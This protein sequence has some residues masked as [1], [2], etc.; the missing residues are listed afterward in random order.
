MPPE[1]KSKIKK[2][3][4]VPVLAFLAITSIFTFLKSTSAQI[5]S[6]CWSKD[7]CEKASCGEA[8]Y[9]ENVTACST[10]S[11]FCYA[12][13]IPT[14]LSIS[15]PGLGEVY[16]PA[17]YISAIY[18]WGVSITGVLAAIM[19]MIGGLLY[20]TAGG[21]PERVSNA[22]EYISHA[23]IGLVLAMTSYL[24]LQTINPALL[25]LKFPKIKLIRTATL[26]TNFCEDLMQSPDIEVTPVDPGKTACGDLGVPKSKSGQTADL[27][28]TCMYGICSDPEKACLPRIDPGV[29]EK[30][31]GCFSCAGVR[32]DGS[33]AGIGPTGA[34]A[35]ANPSDFQSP[36]R[37]YG[38]K[39]CD[40][41]TPLS[42]DS[43]IYACEFLDTN[44]ALGQGPLDSF[45]KFCGDFGTGVMVADLGRGL[46]LRTAR[47]LAPS[48]ARGRLGTLGAAAPSVGVRAGNIA[49]GALVAGEAGQALGQAI[50]NETVQDVGGVVSTIAECSYGAITVLANPMTGIVGGTYAALKEFFTVVLPASRDP[51]KFFGVEGV[52]AIAKIDCSEISSCEDY[53][54]KTTFR[55]QGSTSYGEIL[56]QAGAN[57]GG[58]LIQA[59]N[60][61]DTYCDSNPCQLPLK[62]IAAR[63]Q[64]YYWEPGGARSEIRTPSESIADG[65]SPEDYKCVPLQMYSQALLDTAFGLQPRDSG[66]W[67]LGREGI[68]QDMIYPIVELIPPGRQG[69]GQ[70]CRTNADCATGLSCRGETVSYNNVKEQTPQQR[71]YEQI[72]KEQNPKVVNFQR[73]W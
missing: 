15:L 55:G 33:L 12:Q 14:V 38:Q 73:C 52:C 20:L 48:I 4:I 71:N 57:A 17:Q 29:T 44:A 30:P 19:I 28:T 32:L 68:T 26:P 21:S 65:S 8:C 22:K 59:D 6:D 58:Y 35:A 46:A 27:P 47:K 23:L 16:D 62:C 2:S 3:L 36:R 53:V 60:L 31:A 72:T 42:K 39:T 45:L 54:K 1:K 18:E 43:T 56:A 7:D 70:L 34:W 9:E 13:P 49:I 37:Y 64:W 10:G 24:L 41:L 66:T 63:Q 25:E 51:G 50:E 11:G 61:K 40:A 67:L 5:R 69:K